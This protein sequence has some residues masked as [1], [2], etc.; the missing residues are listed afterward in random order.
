MKFVIFGGEDALVAVCLERYIGAQGKDMEEVKE[1][2]Q[3]AYRAERDDSLARTGTP[4]GDIPAAPDRYH[5][6]VGGQRPWCHARHH[7]CRARR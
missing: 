6:D 1:R 7:R 2:L 5:P 3:T 4:F